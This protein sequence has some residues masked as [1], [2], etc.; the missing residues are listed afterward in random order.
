VLASA[1]IERNKLYLKVSGH[2][3]KQK[4]K[5][6]GPTNTLNNFVFNNKEEKNHGLLH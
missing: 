1:D 6:F 3:R 5:A 4:K 2:V